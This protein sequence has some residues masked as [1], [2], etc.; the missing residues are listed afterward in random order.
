MQNHGR[1]LAD[2]MELQVRADEILHRYKYSRLRSAF[3]FRGFLERARA[4]DDAS[5]LGELVLPLFR[6]YRRRFFL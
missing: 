6:P 5:V 4:A 2:C 3:D 1:L